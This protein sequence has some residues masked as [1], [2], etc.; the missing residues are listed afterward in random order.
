MSSQALQGATPKPSGGESYVDW[1]RLLRALALIAWAGFFAWLWISGEMSRYLGPRTYWVVPFGAAT[2]TCAAL[3]HVATLRT[4]TRR[5][6]PSRTELVG[7]ILLV[8]PLIAVSIVPSADL[9]SL[10][11]SR[12][13]TSA[14]VSAAGE[15][16][17][18]AA[19][20]I[21]N[22]TFRDISYA[23]ESTRYADA[24]GVGDGTEVELLGFV[25]EGEGGPEGTFELTRFYVSCCAADAI[26]YSVA[27]DP[28]AGGE[29][30]DDDDWAEVSGTLERRGDRFVL[31]A[32][33][34]ERVAEPT[35]PYLY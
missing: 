32:D 16:N 27:V 18:Q 11:A 20:I 31:V 3:M 4:S 13:S 33:S 6:L 17:P 15:L 25:D 7:A 19:T 2:L 21:E 5:P 26:P 22:P 8:A 35:E 23:E 29:D 14:G 30:L 34:V 24:I 12:K 1:G 10:A 28:A 9:G